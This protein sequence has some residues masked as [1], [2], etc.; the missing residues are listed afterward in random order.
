[1]HEHTLFVSNVLAHLV[2]LMSGIVSFILAIA[3]EVRKKPHASLAF[4]II[5]AI[6]LLTAFDQAW[7]DEHHN[8]QVLIDQ[9]S[10]ASGKLATC[11]GDLKVTTQKSDFLDS[12][13]KTQ[14]TLINSQLTTLQS[15][16]TSQQQNQ[17]KQQ[18]TL[19]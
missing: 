7:R 17:V 14:Q 3:Q 9:K 19:N 5:G 2:A 18:T 11:A 10:E 4:W 8:T 13:N 15:A 1:M 6:C 16:L 12:Q